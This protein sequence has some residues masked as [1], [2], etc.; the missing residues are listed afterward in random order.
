MMNNDTKCGE[1]VIKL[2]DEQVMRTIKI[3]VGVE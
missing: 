1:R 2:D 3:N